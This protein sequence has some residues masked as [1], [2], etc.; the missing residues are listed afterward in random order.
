MD[1]TKEISLENKL[2]TNSFYVTYIFL[3]TT[4]TITFIES[5]RTKSPEIRN[6]LNLE[7]CISIIAAYFYG[8]F[9][10]KLNDK[11]ID[12][13]KMNE[14]RYTDWAITTPIMLLVL[15]LAFLYNTQEGAMSF[16][17]YLIILVLNY[18]MLGF[19][20]IGEIGVMDKTQ[21]NSLGFV[22][23]IGLYYYIYA[24]YIEGR[25]NNDNRILYFAFLILWALYGVFYTMES[26]IK[27]I[28][29]NILDLLSKCFVGIFFWAYFTGTFKI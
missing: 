12:Y 3:L 15:V 17:S 8:E 5:I 1:S 16:T 2:I 27:N 9:V 19:G 22:A 4:G 24:N 26:T 13:E 23:F 20:Y 10:K 21:S 18:L 6:I 14:T 29:Y 11:K 7:T 25:D 28:G